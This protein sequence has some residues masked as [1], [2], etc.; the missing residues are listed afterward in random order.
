MEDPWGLD[1]P[2]FELW[3]FFSMGEDVGKGEAK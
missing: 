2:I 3:G 1:P